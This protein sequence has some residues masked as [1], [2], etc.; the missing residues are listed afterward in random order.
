M[1]PWLSSPSRVAEG[2]RTTRRCISIWRETD[3]IATPV[4][5][6]DNHDNFYL[7]VGSTEHAGER[8]Q[9]QFRPIEGRYYDR[10]Q[11]HQ[12]SDN[13]GTRGTPFARTTIFV[14]LRPAIPIPERAGLS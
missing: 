6:I 7:L 13:P 14:I 11:H 12:F 10:N 5:F 8:A 3:I 2:D 1:T 4:W 9:K